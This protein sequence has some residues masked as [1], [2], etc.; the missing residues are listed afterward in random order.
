MA[1]G[2]FLD[3]ESIRAGAVAQMK[4][5]WVLLPEAEA[6]S[7][8]RCVQ[9]L[10][11]ASFGACH[12]ICAG[13]PIPPG[14]V[15]TGLAGRNSAH[16][17]GTSWKITNANGALDGDTIHVEEMLET[18]P[19][20]PGG[21]LISGTEKTGPGSVSCTITRIS[22]GQEAEA[23]AAPVPLPEE[24]RTGTFTVIHPFPTAI[25]V[26]EAER[27]LPPG[28]APAS[29]PAARPSPSRTPRPGLAP[30]K[31]GPSPKRPCHP[32]WR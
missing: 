17:A 15:R 16:P 32:R 11:G 23:K 29:P 28:Q 4:P 26:P 12:W 2:A 3:I 5:G 27:K 13:S 31:Q 8:W 9:D 22:P 14:W 18:D 21:W 6:G 10:N 7:G 25:H 24:D 19:P 1:W 30:A 20:F